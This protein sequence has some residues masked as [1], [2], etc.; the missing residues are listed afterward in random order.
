S[1]EDLRRCYQAACA[2]VDR[3][4]ERLQQGVADLQLTDIA[5]VGEVQRPYC[6]NFGPGAFEAAVEKCKEDI[7]ARDALQIVL[8]QRLETETRARPFDSYRTLR[9]VNPSPFMFYLK[10]GPLCLVGASPEIL[11][12]VEGDRV[13]IRPLA[14]TRRRGKTEEEDADLAAELLGDPKE[15]AEPIMLVDLGRNDIGRVA[16]YGTVQLSDVMTVERYSHVMHISS[17][18]T[19]RLHAGKTA[20]DALRSC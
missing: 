14:G 12:R 11:V 8:S 16:R 19:G 15:R 2:R 6:S 18:V 3:L 7:K 20:F 13:T 10:A 4:V 1:Q 17:T 5:P 9:V